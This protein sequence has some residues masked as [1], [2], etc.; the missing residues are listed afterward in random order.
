MSARADG[1]PTESRFERWLGPLGAGLA[2]VGLLV[3]GAA[4]AV[5]AGRSPGWAYD[6]GAYFGAAERLV[7]TGRPTSSRLLPDPFDRGRT[8]SIFT[9]RHWP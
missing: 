5:W 7:A 8:G 3:I 2:L 6:F 1:A 9:R 4:F